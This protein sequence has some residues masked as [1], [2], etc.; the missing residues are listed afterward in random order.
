[1]YSE[2][3]MKAFYLRSLKSTFF[4]SNAIVTI[5]PFIV[6]IIENIVTIMRIE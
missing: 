6:I 3:L 1:M 5:N 2:L 4:S